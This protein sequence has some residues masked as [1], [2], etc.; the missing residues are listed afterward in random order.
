MTKKQPQTGSIF[1]YPYLWSHEKDAGRE[2]PK[3]R[4]VCL[5]V[6][7]K[8]QTGD[9]H[10]VL[11]P[12]SDNAPSPPS[13]SIA[14]PE[15]EKRRAGLDPSRAAYVHVDDYNVDI[16]QRSWNYDPRAKVFGRFGKAFTAKISSALMQAIKS[17]LSLRIDRT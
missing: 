5:I 4:T 16:L 9:D 2:N 17:G 6:K 10:I 13:L 15:I 8:H 12:I 14:V 3:N 1:H 11:L 7:I